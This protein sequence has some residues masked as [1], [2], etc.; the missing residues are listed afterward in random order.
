MRNMI[1]VQRMR[2]PLPGT[3]ALA[4]TVL[5]LLAATLLATADASAAA[6]PLAHF[7]RIIFGHHS[8][9]LADFETFAR[10]AKQ[11]GAT[12]IVLTAEDLPWAT[13]QLDTP[14]DPYPAWAM[15][16]IGLL[17]IATPA[18]LKPYL[19]QDYADKVMEIL[20][21]RCAVLRKLGL[22]A[23]FT[24]FEPQM[25]PEAVYEAH[26][27]W[28]GPQVDHPI[29]SRVPR[30]A[31]SI[32]NPEV[33]ALYRESIRTLL[34]ACPEIEIL[35]LHTN[36]SGSGVSWSGGLYEGPNGNSLY[37]SL[38]MHQR[39]RDFFGALQAGARDA[40]TSGL[41]I[42]ADWV[43]ESAPE[44]IAGRLAPGMAVAN[45]E[46]PGATPY[47]AEVG[48]LLD[49]F[50]PF[51]PAQ[52]LPLPVRYLEELEKG[53]RSAAPRLFYLMG[54][55]FDSD[56]Y[57]RLY[58]AFVK[59]PTR[60]EG[61]RLS[62][63]RAIA[64]ER[65]GE[66]GASSLV[67]AWLAL[68]L[69]QRD[70]DI[71]NFGGTTFYIGA[72]H[73]RW[74][75][76]PFVPFPE[77]LTPAE[78]QYYRKYQFQARTEERARDLDELQGTHQYQGLGGM[79][80][81]DKLYVRM[82]AELERARGDVRKLRETGGATQRQQYELLDRRLQ[83]FQALVNN[84]RDAIEYQYYLDIAKGW[85]LRRTVEKQE[86]LT[87]IPEWRAIRDTA[88]REIDNSAVLIDLL[89]SQPALLIDL[90]KS[91]GEE[92]IRVLGPDLV[93]QL[94]RKIKIM[95]AHWEDYERLFIKESKQADKA[96]AIPR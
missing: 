53:S 10:R 6:N 9:S 85:K 47:K 3:R 34:A 52:G 24:T 66:A 37:R 12:H 22:K 32:D 44:L 45:L 68:H 70:T 90:A 58:D 16:N 84:C 64:A 36:D 63:L 29:R 87:D 81:S 1:L 73:Q 89:Q 7:T 4:L 96:A 25:L 18:A 19:P 71:L 38:P 31:P 86:D 11:S 65:A 21:A 74:L 62:L 14:G 92:N 83:V 95:I 8:D 49:Y 91:S 20:R 2:Q 46:G 15:S 69:I 17:K 59:S 94:R 77:E 78:T 76:R 79:A 42:D 30:F 40:G 56:L 50:Y 54:D 35:S 41:E 72:V 82:L 93:D 60:D 39:Y 88:R 55:R 28:R 26:P 75:T 33:L 5:F 67:D 13:W 23:A 48:F 80:L 51:Y 27:L 61:S 43:R 57:F